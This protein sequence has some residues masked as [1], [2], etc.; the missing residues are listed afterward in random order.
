LTQSN[1]GTVWQKLPGGD[2]AE[3][4]RKAIACYQRALE[5]FTPGTDLQEWVTTSFGLD[6]LRKLLDT[7]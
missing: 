2:R 7:L 3:N 6:N 4:L 5:V 1:L